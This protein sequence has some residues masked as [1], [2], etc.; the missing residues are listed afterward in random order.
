[1]PAG[2]QGETVTVTTTSTD[3]ADLPARCWVAAFSA[4]SSNTDVVRVMMSGGAAT[5]G[6][7]A[8]RPG[9]SKTFSLAAPLLAYGLKG[10]SLLAHH[11]I[12]RIN[13]R[14][15]SGSQSL[16]IDYQGAWPE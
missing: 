13:H 11:F 16:D 15:D 8:I 4:P 3:L 1:M 12:T 9:Q 5:A 2:A 6:S 10:T 7:L 14:A